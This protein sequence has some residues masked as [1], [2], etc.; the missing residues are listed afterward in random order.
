[1]KLGR[2]GEQ[3]VAGLGRDIGVQHGGAG[4]LVFTALG[5]CLVRGDHDHLR[6]ELRLEIIRGDPFVFRV[7][8]AVEQA[9]GHRFVAARPDFLRKL[10]E[11]GF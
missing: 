6:V 11:F 4:A 3:M 5:G 7:H 8:V 2:K 1:M 10:R 9:D